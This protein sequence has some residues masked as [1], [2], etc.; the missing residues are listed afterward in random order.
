M[1]KP[2]LVALLGLVLIALSAGEEENSENS[3][4]ALETEVEQAREVREADPKRKKKK[5]N[6]AKKRSKKNKSKKKKKGKKAAKRGKKKHRSMKKKGKKGKKGKM[7]RNKKK[8]SKGR[9]KKGKGKKK[10]NRKRGKKNKRNKKKKTKKIKPVEVSRTTGCSDDAC[11]TALAK[12]MNQYNTKYRNFEVQKTRI[13]KFEKLTGNKGGKKDAFKTIKGQIRE[14]GGGNSSAFKCGD[15]TSGSGVNLIKKL[16][17]NLTACSADI[18]TACET[19]KPK[20]NQ[21]LLTACETK[22]KAFKDEAEKCLKSKDNATAACVCWKSSAM[23]TA[24]DMI[25]PCVKP[26]AD[27][28]GKFAS[29][30]KNCT[31]SFAKCRQDEDRGSKLIYG[32]RPGFK[33][34][35]LKK[36]FDAKKNKASL[37]KL[38]TEIGKKAARR[39]VRTALSCTVF[40]TQCTGLITFAGNALLM[41]R[42]A[43]DA[44]TLVANAPTAACSAADKTALTALIAPLDMVLANLDT[45]IA[46]IESDVQEITGS[47]PTDSE[48]AAAGTTAAP[49]ATTV[50]SSGRF[51]FQNMVL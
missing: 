15:S 5:K 47:K 36:L 16:F 4:Q 29:F 20:I 3:L 23:K 12:Y 26:I 48:I 44:D 50:K 34:N 46:D 11:L 14:A 1:N 8:K 2:L 42:I 40:V 43:T 32:C 24:S 18:K 39:V 13:G 6:A 21:T 45:A 31:Q 30:K 28:N 7:N 38:K 25:E 35:Q 27:L 49:T 22:M 51:H 19:N 37:T 9:K 10:K 33:A 41:P 17:D